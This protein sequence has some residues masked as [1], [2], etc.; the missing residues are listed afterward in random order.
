MN[1]LAR[2][3]VE[4]TIPEQSNNVFDF[5]TGKPIS[6][7]NVITTKLNSDYK[8]MHEAVQPIKDKEDIERAKVYFYNNIGRYTN[9]NL[10][11]RN[12]CMFIMGINVGRRIGD[13]LALRICDVMNQDK[14]IKDKVTIIREQKTKK[15]ATF[16][17]APEVKD[18]IREYI[19]SRSGY[20]MTD[21]LFSSRKRNDV[22]G[23]CKPISRGQAWQ[24]WHDMGESLGIERM[25]TH[26]G[27]KTKG[28]QYMVEHKGD[29]YALAKVSKAYGHSKQEI[30]LDYLGMDDDEMKDFYVGNVL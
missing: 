8:G 24:I 25:G 19:S 29:Y 3:R 7:I 2:V 9:S 14:T 17:F 5:S 4:Q 16:Y 27:R 28:Y 18:A 22:T 21:Y 15:K 6:N 20:K 12:Y 13:L 23:E 1:E 11:L 10:N 30:T 26:S